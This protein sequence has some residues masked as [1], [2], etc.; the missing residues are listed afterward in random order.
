MES[1]F[2]LYEEIMIFG[3]SPIRLDSVYW[4][5]SLA[6]RRFDSS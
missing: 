2:A 4:D 1:R 5:W 3:V 6:Q